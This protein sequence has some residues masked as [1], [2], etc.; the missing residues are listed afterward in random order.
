MKKES[1]TWLNDFEGHY[2][3]LRLNDARQGIGRKLLLITRP[4]RKLHTSFQMKR[5]SSTLDDLKG[6]YCNRNYK[7]AACFS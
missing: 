3:L 6:Q 2:A 7:A 4:N 1:L 5:K